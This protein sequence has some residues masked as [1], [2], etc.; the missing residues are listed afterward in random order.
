MKLFSLSVNHPVSL[1]KAFGSVAW[2]GRGRGRPIRLWLRHGGLPVRNRG[3][4]QPYRDQPRSAVLN[5]T[6]KWA[7]TVCAPG[8]STARSTATTSP[9]RRD[10]AQP[11]PAPNQPRLGYSDTLPRNM[12]TKHRPERRGADRPRHGDAKLCVKC[13]RLAEFDERNRVDGVIVPAW[14]C[15]E[16]GCDFMEHVRRTGDRGFTSRRTATHG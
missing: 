5:C 6:L 16:L 13:R 14:I 3:E 2:V 4:P 12:D 15:N 11:K 8:S 1:R 10:E 9:T 7:L